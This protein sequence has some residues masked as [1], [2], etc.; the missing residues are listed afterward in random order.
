MAAGFAVLLWLQCILLGTNEQIVNDVTSTQV[1]HLQ[2][3]RGEY[4]D[5]P[6]LSY[7]FPENLEKMK[8]SLP[9][10][11]IAAERLFLPAL[12]SSGEQSVPIQLTGVDPL[13][14]SQVTQIK[15]TKVDGEYLSTTPDPDCKEREVYLGKSLVDLL[16]VGI[17]DKVV[18]LAQA[19]DGTLGN[20]L[21]RVKGL[22]DTGSRTFDRSVAY[23]SLSCVRKIGVLSGAHEIVVRLP[24]GAKVA[25]ARA[26][27]EKNISSLN[28]KLKVTTW[29]EAVPPL[30]GMVTFNEATLLLISLV[31][32]GVTAFSVVNTLLM[33]V[34]ERTREFGVMLALGVTPNG[35]CALILVE[36]A[37][38]GILSAIIGT[39][40]GAGWVY[41]HHQ[42]GF[43]LQPFLGSSFAVSQFKLNTTIHPIF[44]FDRYFILVGATMFFATLA[45]LVPALHASKMDVVEAIRHR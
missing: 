8:A 20:E 10:G 30:A 16:K 6:L 18:I 15:G 3:W 28:K 1:G 2:I 12:I 4:L 31:L 44:S 17:G 7:T 35:V 45:G 38:I 43:D 26:S 23:A 25:T 39:L 13:Q 37:F 19:S 22:F 11:A 42:V 36:A 27:I 34:F 33:S 32:F 41:Y 14:E 5:E 21:L 40:I 9:Q 24:A 29:R